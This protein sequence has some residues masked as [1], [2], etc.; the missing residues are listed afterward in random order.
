MLA[1]LNSMGLMGWILLCEAFWR[2][3]T[4][5]GRLVPLRRKPLIRFQAAVSRLLWHS[6]LGGG[7]FG[8][9][10]R[11]PCSWFKNDLVLWPLPPIK[12]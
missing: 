8:F 3:N 4:S 2:F 6:D 1:A 12:L 5:T 9:S 11:R 10:I 7:R